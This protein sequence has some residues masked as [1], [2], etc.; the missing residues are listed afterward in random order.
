MSF[1]KVILATMVI[2]GCGVVTGALV[3]RAQTAQHADSPQALLRPL[4]R[5][6]PNMPGQLQNPELLRR[7][8]SQLNLTYEQRQSIEKIMKASQERTKPLW[9]EIGPQMQKELAR[10]R[11]EIEEQLTPDQKTKF[12]Q[13][14][15]RGRRGEGAGKRDDNPLW[16]H[17]NGV[18]TN[19]K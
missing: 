2:F 9:E 17:T 14:F 12:G 3:M 6:G 7:M 4:P 10:T 15:Q 11:E 1:W 8:D 13:M 18:D 5:P 19:G 16:A